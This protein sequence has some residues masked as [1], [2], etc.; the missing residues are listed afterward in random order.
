MTDN[1]STAIVPVKSAWVSKINWAQAISVLASFLALKGINLDPDTQANI[2]TAI[3]SINAV[4]TW[5]M[6]TWFNGSV[7]PSSLPAKV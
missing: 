1:V 4:V 5:V 2:L 7:S 3:V 6:R